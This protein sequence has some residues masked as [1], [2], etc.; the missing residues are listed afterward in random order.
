MVPPPSTPTAQHQHLVGP[1][2]TNSRHASTW[3]ARTLTTHQPS[4]W[5]TR[6]TNHPATTHSHG[7]CGH[8][9]IHHAHG[10]PTTAARP[11]PRVHNADHHAPCSMLHAPLTHP[12]HGRPNQHLVGRRSTNSRHASTWLARTHTPGQP[13]PRTGPHIP[14]TWLR[15]NAMVAVA[16][17]T[18]TTTMVTDPPPNV[19]ASDSPTLVNI[20]HLHT[21]TVMHGPPP[22]TPTAQPTPG[23]STVHRQPTCF[24]MARSHAHL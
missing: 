3:L 22:S 2:S 24:H 13:S 18:P 4:P 1:R 5:N 8:R 17:V 19:L 11:G 20:P 21:R 9:S 10:H 14:T 7:C 15:L 12:T 23:R 6:H 16:T